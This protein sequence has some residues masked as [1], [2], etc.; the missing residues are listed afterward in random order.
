MISVLYVE[1]RL[2]ILDIISRFLEK[3]GDVVVES[4][5]SAPE[6]LQKMDHIS[7]DVIVTDYHSGESTGFDLLRQTRQKGIMTPFVFFTSERDYFVDSETR[8]YDLVAFVPKLRKS[9][10]G[11]DELEKAIRTIISESKSASLNSEKDSK[12]LMHGEFP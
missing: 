6:A 3:K 11:F 2:P 12:L 10:S 5:R 1:D 4:S 9:G 7:F 8:R